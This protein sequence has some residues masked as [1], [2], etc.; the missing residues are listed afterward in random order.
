MGWNY[1]S[2]PILQQCNRWSL[3]MDKQFYPRLY[4]GCNYLSMLGLKLNHVSKSGYRK[5]RLRS[6]SLRQRHWLDIKVNPSLL[7]I[8]WSYVFFA[9]TQGYLDSL[10]YITFS[11]CMEVILNKQFQ[12][13]TNTRNI[14]P[15]YRI[16][17]GL[18]CSIYQN[19]NSHTTHRW[20]SARLCYL[21]C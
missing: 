12:H 6:T 13:T 4:N 14:F 21:Y 1:L 17:N 20:L 10:I 18:W 8:W 11:G 3:G 5:Q 2:I 7:A 15:R 19:G 16:L 9:Q